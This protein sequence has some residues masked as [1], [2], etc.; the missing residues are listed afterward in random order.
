MNQERIQG[1]DRWSD[2]VTS[3]PDT[4][5]GKYLRQFWQPVG[6]SSEV[7]A[8]KAIP[9]HVMDEKFTL[10]R[11]ESGT[12]HVVAHKCSHRSAQLSTGWVKGDT[13]QCMYHGWKFDGQ[14]CC[15][16]RPGEKNTAAFPQANI[17]SYPTQEYLGLIYA[18]FGEG[19]PPLF[20]PFKEY[21]DIGVIENHA[22]IFPC[23]W[24]QT[25]ENHFDETHIAFVHTFGDSHDDLGRKYEMPEMNIY[26]TD[27]GMIRESKVSGG[28]LRKVHY[29]LPNIMRIMIPTFNDLMEVGGWRDT[30]IIIVP[31]D[32]KNHRVYF[33]M[34]VHIEEKD[35]VAY[36]AMNERFNERVKSHPPIH[37]LTHDI[38]AGKCHINDHLD[39]PHLLLLEDGIAQAGQGHMVDRTRE[40]LGRT[41]AG[42][43]A[44]RKVFEREMKAVENGEATTAWAPMTVEPELGF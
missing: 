19:E 40:T 21:E 16:E 3:G 13:I 20:P 27:Y 44:M 1:K 36:H 4:I 34:N 37:E 35:M 32:D 39:H 5:G 15:V 7:A 31:T 17:A 33:T 42:I 8:G 10:F 28:K 6:M 25:M 24:F 38:L 30:N 29:L 14:G 2:Y 43:S 23:N 26:E 22:L 18:Y 9:I 41:D 11:G 12:A